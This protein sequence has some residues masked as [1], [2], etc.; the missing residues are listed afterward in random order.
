M[1]AREIAVKNP[2]KKGQFQPYTAPLYLGRYQARHKC[3]YSFNCNPYLGCLHKCKYCFSD[4]IQTAKHTRFD[5][6]RPADIEK[7]ESHIINGI[8]GK[9]HDK[10]SKCLQMRIPIK[11]GAMTDP[12]QPAEKEF[13]I[14]LRLLELLNRQKYPVIVNTKGSLVA[15]EPYI[16]LLASM[17]SVVQISLMSMNDDL[18]SR[19]EPYVPSPKDRIKII[20]KLS[21]AGIVTQ[22]R[23]APII[24]MVNEDI[25]DVVSAAY[26]AGAKDVLFHILFM[27]KNPYAFEKLSGALGFNYLK[28]LRNN[29]HWAF[30][31]KGYSYSMSDYQKYIDS[32]KP[33]VARTGMGFYP[34]NPP[35]PDNPWTSCCGVEKYPGFENN[36][37]WVLMIRGRKIGNHTSF[38]EYIRGSGCPYV[39]DFK[40][41]WDSGVLDQVIPGIYFNPEDKTYSRMNALEFE[42]MC[43]ND[44]KASRRK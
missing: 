29:K 17:P 26:L 33:I 39:A 42:R 44:S 23:A 32:V 10:I 25:S 9:Q 27:K 41:K 2:F 37:S 8:K 21:E 12:F 7:M 5:Y 31:G 1:P 22:L 40:R 20:S 35:V 34:E 38:A 13:K 6:V 24:P 30:D 19:L 36:M 28:T 11:I 15:E 16:S 3:P 43:E 18:I 4:H 14:T